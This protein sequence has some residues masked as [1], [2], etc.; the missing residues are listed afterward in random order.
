MPYRIVQSKQNPRL[1]ELRRALAEPPRLGG[2]G[3][4]LGLEGGHLLEEALRA[5]LNIHAVFVAEGAEGLVEDLARRFPL[6][7]ELETLVVPREI[8]LAA[9][10]TE[11]PQSVAALAEAPVWKLGDLAARGDGP[12]LALAGLQDPGNLGTIL[13][14]AEAFGA[15]GMILLPGT[16]NPWNAKALRSSAGSALRL[17]MVAAEADAAIAWLK[18]N[19]RKIFTTAVEGAEPIGRVNLKAAHAFLIGNE[20]AGVAWEIA[21][22]ADAAVTIPM[23]GAVESLNAAV[24]A[25]ILLYECA[26]Q[27]EGP[28]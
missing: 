22:L 28:R 14:S 18:T 13:R 19:G 12:V 3:G 23:P 17:P 15:A 5:G 27:R 16:V 24:A 4:L 26:R 10:S 7:T 20:G 11:T 21:R 2:A 25:S 6:L 1:K 9:Q 8:L